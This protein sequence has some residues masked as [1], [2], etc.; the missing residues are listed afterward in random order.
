VRHHT[1]SE[2]IQSTTIRPIA[3]NKELILDLTLATEQDVLQGKGIAMPLFGSY[4]SKYQLTVVAPAGC[5]PLT[6]ILAALTEALTEALAA[7][8]ALTEV[9]TEALTEALAAPAA[10]TEALTEALAAPAALTEAL[11]EAL[12]ASGH[13]KS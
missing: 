3:P 2:K 12:A 7:P 6:E 13:E 10:L 5:P 9:L 11:M 8:A 1:R 4:T